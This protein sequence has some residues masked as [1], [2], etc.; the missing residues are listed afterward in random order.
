[1]S[2][3]SGLEEMRRF[4]AR[5]E[6]IEDPELQSEFLAQSGRTFDAVR[7]FRRLINAA[8]RVPRVPRPD[9]RNA[10]HRARRSRP[11]PV[12]PAGR[13]R[14]RRRRSRTLVI[15]VRIVVELS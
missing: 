6:S 2:D 1:M 10:R 7:H 14:H 5:Y 3:D 9:L 4:V 8:N 11:T 13:P 12:G 15:T